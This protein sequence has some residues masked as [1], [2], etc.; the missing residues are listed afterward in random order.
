MI[1][2]IGIDIEETGRVRDM[3]SRYENNFLERIFTHQEI[4]YCQGKSDPPVHFTARFAAK[5]AFSKAIGTGWRGS[6]RWK[7]IEI[8]N[9]ALG[10]P[11]IILYNEAL[12]QFSACAVHVTLSHSASYAV[13][14]VVIEELP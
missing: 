8:E 5:E 12:E 2:G 9:D 1:R 3:M 14:F 13:A 11:A 7:D 10:K 4:Q 6:F